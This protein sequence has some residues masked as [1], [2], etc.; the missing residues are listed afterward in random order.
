LS[1]LFFS[2]LPFNKETI[3]RLL[4]LPQPDILSLEVISIKMRINFGELTAI[5]N[6]EFVDCIDI[7][8]Y[9]RIIQIQT[10]LI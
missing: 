1:I 7:L 6:V 4:R 5:S 10:F 2:L 9:K 3:D 8:D